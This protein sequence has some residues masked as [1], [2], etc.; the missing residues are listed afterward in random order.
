MVWD[1]KKRGNILEENRDA[2]TAQHLRNKM[3]DM[4]MKFSLEPQIEYDGENSNLPS[5]NIDNERTLPFEK[6]IVARECVLTRV[7]NLQK[8][9][10][11]VKRNLSEPKK[12]D[13]PRFHNITKHS[14]DEKRMFHGFHRNKVTLTYNNH[15]QGK[16]VKNVEQKPHPVLGKLH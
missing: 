16:S 12:F 4:N 14:L 6:K 13:A 9:P 2:S 10:K 7:G 3:G 11:N 15:F 5:Y 8:L 1:A